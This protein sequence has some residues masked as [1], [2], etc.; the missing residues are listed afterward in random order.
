MKTLRSFLYYKGFTTLELLLVI[1]I[2]ATLAAIAIPMYA[3]KIEK[4]KIARA[5]ADIRTIGTEL[6]AYEIENKTYPNSLTD[7]RNPVPLDSWGNS[8]KYTKVAGAVV[9][10]LRK[11][12]FLVP[13]NTD[14]DL[15]SMGKDGKSK[16]PLTAKDSWDD[17]VRANNGTYVGLASEY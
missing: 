5:T 11:D 12:K 2:V 14:F 10:G 16:P 1:A 8:Y 9:G 4:A 7:I 17:I 6:S 3:D 13:L 15:Y